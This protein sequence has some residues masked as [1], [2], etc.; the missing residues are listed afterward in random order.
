MAPGQCS[1]ITSPLG[2]EGTFPRSRISNVEREAADGQKGKVYW[3]I[4][5]GNQGSF[6]GIDSEQL[7]MGKGKDMTWTQDGSLGPECPLQR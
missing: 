5:C 6:C 1:I 3:E 4:P 2:N 7:E